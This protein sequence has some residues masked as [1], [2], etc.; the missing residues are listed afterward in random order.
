MALKYSEALTTAKKVG[1]VNKGVGCILES[2]VRVSMYDDK[3]DTASLIRAG[4]D[5]ENCDVSGMWNALRKFEM[6]YIQNETGHSVKG[7]MQTRSAAKIFEDSK[8]LEPRAFYAIYAYYIDQSF[9]WVP[10]KSDRR[11]EYLS[12]LDSATINSSRFWP[13][14]LV[15]L[16]WMH[17]DNGNFEKGLKLSERGLQKAPNHPVML[18]IKADMLY[19]LKRYSEAASIYEASASDYLERTGKSIRYWCSIL[20]LI[21]IYHDAG[22]SEKKSL[23]Q[24]KIKDPEF[25]SL[26]HWMPGSLMGDLKKRNLIK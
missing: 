1:A 26:K 6:G 20:N 8:E 12:T 21:R 16:I 10:F 11:K 3:G 7:A 24:K 9:S 5:L 19:R 15:P 22:N 4:K 14:F 23:Y 13:L 17:Y 25:E 18:Q 2:I